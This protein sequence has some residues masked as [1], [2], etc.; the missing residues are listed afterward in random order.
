MKEQSEINLVATKISDVS[1]LVG[2]VPKE[3][4]NSHF[5]FSYQA[6]D[7]VLP[8]VRNAC[9]EVGLIIVPNIVSVERGGGTTTVNT[10]FQLIDTDSGQVLEQHF[11]GEAKGTDD[12]AIQKAMTSSTK[13]AYLKMFQI[14]V[15]GDV[16]P[17]GEAPKAEAGPVKTP[18][19]VTQDAAPQINWVERG[20]AAFGGD[21]DA[22][23]AWT[24]S[25]TKDKVAW[26]V[27]LKK[28]W[29]TSGDRTTQVELEA[30][31]EEERHAKNNGK[32]KAPSQE[33][34]VG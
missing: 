21:K 3:G 17:D 1:R 22:W 12:K 15:A 10:L 30:A 32:A 34:L 18:S 23:D 26:G 25:A 9:V 8:A 4:Y 7:D 33:A 27:I 20:I 13:Y 6:W 31:L 11:A 29:A 28:I 16:D 5:K 24:Q 14:P 2:N 19:P